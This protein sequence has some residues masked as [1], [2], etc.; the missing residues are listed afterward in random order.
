[1]SKFFMLDDVFS[2]LQA[3]SQSDCI[4]CPGGYYCAEKTVTPANCGLG[5][6]SKIGQDQCLDCKPG[7]V[8]FV[9]YNKLG[10]YL[11]IRWWFSKG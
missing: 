8:T 7:W 9:T 3:K 2:G 10:E 4:A 6:Y 1:M 11:V 5:K